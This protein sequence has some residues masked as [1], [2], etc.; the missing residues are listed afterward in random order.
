MRFYGAGTIRSRGQFCLVQ[1]TAGDLGWVSIVGI[2]HPEG[3][4][5]LLVPPSRHAGAGNAAAF[6]AQHYSDEYRAHLVDL[7]G[8]AVARDTRMAAAPSTTLK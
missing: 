3:G 6:Y 4:T 1:W 2:S 8:K 7:K 5:A